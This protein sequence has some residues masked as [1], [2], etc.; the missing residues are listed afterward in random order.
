MR[1]VQGG[2]VLRS[3]IAL[4]FFNGPR[5]GGT[6]Q[7]R[8]RVPM[9]IRD[10]VDGGITTRFTHV[11]LVRA[12]A[13]LRH[14]AGVVRVGSCHSR[15]QSKCLRT[16]CFSHS[17]ILALSVVVLS[18]PFPSKTSRPRS[19][20][21]RIWEK[22]NSRPLYAKDISEIERI[23]RGAPAVLSPEEWPARGPQIFFL[24]NSDFCAL[25][26]I[27]APTALVVAGRSLSSTAP[28]GEADYCARK[29][30]AARPQPTQIKTIR[31]PALHLFSPSRSR[32]QWYGNTGK[33][34]IRRP[35]EGAETRTS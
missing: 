5:P 15:R 20:H 13:K 30:T 9:A 16:I 19:G 32:A 29:A 6:R 23:P 28:A 8:A 10:V 4:L 21:T 26:Q 24:G 31:E 17:I 2:F 27:R 25:L 3:S 22:H 14:G 1:V 34:R 33:Q 12:W 35:R 7:N 18:N 11:A